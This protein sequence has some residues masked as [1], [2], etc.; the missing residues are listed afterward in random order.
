MCCDHL[1]KGK[2]A[3]RCAAITS[4]GERARV[5]VLLVCSRLAVSSLL[6]LLLVQD[7]DCDI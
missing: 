1:T 6:L 4:L 7:E 5:G 3:S 2:G